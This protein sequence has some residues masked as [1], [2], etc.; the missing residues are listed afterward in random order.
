MKNNE[1]Y[2]IPYDILVLAT[3]GNSK[4][5]EIEGIKNPSVYSFYNI[6]DAEK[7]IKELE[8]ASAKDVLIIGGGLVGV[9]TS[10]SLIESGA[11]VTII[12]KDLS[13]LLNYFD[14][15]FAKKIEKE[16]S[17]K[18]IKIITSCKIEKI[19][20][21][22]NK[23]LIRTDNGIFVSDFIILSAGVEPNIE[24]AKEA[25]LELGITGGIK[26]DKYLRTSD[27]N[28]YAAGDCAETFHYITKKPAYWPLG[29]VSIKMG[30]IVANNI[31]G[32]KTTFKGSLGTTLFKVFDLTC[33]RTGLTTKKAK[34]AGF[35]VISAIVTGLDKEHYSSNSQ[36]IFLKLIADKKTKKILGAQGIGKG[37]VSKRIQILASSISCGATVG[38]VFNLDLGYFPHFNTPIDICQSA[39][40]I[41]QNKFLGLFKSLEFEDFTKDKNI[42]ILDVSPQQDNLLSFFPSSINIPLENL[43]N[44]E[45]PFSKEE[46]ILILS[47]TSARAY[48]AYRYMEN[49]GYKNIYILEGG[50]I[51]WKDLINY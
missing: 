43:R 8:E 51:F 5:P 47:R 26:V 19:E 37:M 9:E 31:A 21:M 41:L 29:S 39:C 16:L 46:K 25:G 10:E 38:E 11:R 18:G 27:P 42:R 45:I 1:E 40:M 50:F 28:I 14:F 17:Q 4:I 49:L 33:A 34:E 24:L 44:E 35:D 7:I 15:E 30:R 48:E 23:L 2:F 12:E 22:E 36:Y 3:G 32:I 6:E 20:N 13:I